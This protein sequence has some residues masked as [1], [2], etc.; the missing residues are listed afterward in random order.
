M[1]TDRKKF[2]LYLHPGNGADSRALKAIDEVPKNNRGELFRNVFMAGL[3]LHRLDSR[4]PIMVAELSAGDLTADQLIEL[5]AL[6]TGWQPT[7]ADIKSVLE[8]MGTMVLPPQGIKEPEQ[9]SSKNEA[10]KKVK[11]KLA[12][13]V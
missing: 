5:T 8:N 6:L 3:A 10:L 4:L 1:S 7:K 12:G 13:F 2:T 11:N 9:D